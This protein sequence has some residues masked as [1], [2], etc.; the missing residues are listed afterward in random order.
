MVWDVQPIKVLEWAFPEPMLA[1]VYSASC[2]Q[3]HSPLGQWGDRKKEDSEEEGW[4]VVRR[5]G[6]G[7]RGLGES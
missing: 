2:L 7:S 4:G 5:E 6:G 3:R 1:V